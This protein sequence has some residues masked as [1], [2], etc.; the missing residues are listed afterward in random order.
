MSPRHRLSR[1]DGWPG[2]NASSQNPW[3]AARPARNPEHAAAMKQHDIK[4][5][6][7]VCINLYPSL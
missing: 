6:D 2:K 4:P 1:D 5:I 3:R 7:L